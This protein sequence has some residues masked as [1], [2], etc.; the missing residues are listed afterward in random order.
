MTQETATNYVYHGPLTPVAMPR[1]GHLASH[2]LRHA[3]LRRQ[4][5]TRAHRLGTLMRHFFLPPARPV[6]PLAPGMGTASLGGALIPSPSLAL[7]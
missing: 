4:Y 3:E 7:A 1:R 6:A 2:A 5:I